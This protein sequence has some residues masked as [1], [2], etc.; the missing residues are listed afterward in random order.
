MSWIRQS[1]AALVRLL[2]RFDYPTKFGVVAIV[3]GFAVSL[4]LQ[5]VFDDHGLTVGAVKQEVAALE[6]VDD[7]LALVVDAQLHR[8]LTYAALQ[9]DGGGFKAM[10][11][12]RAAAV[13]ARMSELDAALAAAPAL[14]V[15][16]PRWDRIRQDLEE[17]LRAADG[18]ATGEHVFERY[19]IAIRG[20]LEWMSDVG[21]ASGLGGDGDPALLHL[22]AA[23]LRSL[24]L[25]VE[26]I[27]NLRG[28][29]TGTLVAKRM[30][31]RT[32]LRLAARLEAVEIAESALH[33]R[34]GAIRADVLDMQAPLIRELHEAVRYI[35]NTAR[36][37]IHSGADSIDPIDFFA[38]ASLAIQH[39]LE[40][41][42]QHLSRG[43]RELLEQR[44]QAAAQD[45]WTSVAGSAAVCAL[46]ALLFA[47]MYASIRRAVAELERGSER[48]AAGALETRVDI[49]SRDELRTVGEHF[50]AM[51][52][53]I[54]GL[55][56]AQREQGRRLE[57]AASVFANAREGIIITDRGGNIVD[58]NGAFTTITGWARD[59]VM[60]KNPRLLKSGRQGAD[61][62]RAMWAVLAEKGYWEGEV[63]NCDKQGKAF[64]EA[65]AISAVRDGDGEVSHYVALISDITRQKE[66]EQRLRRLAHF[67]V[68]TGLPN[69]SLLA[70]RLEQALG[71]ARRSGKPVAVALIDLDGFKAINDG[72]GHEAGDALLVTVARRMKACLRTQD[73]I[74][75]MGG[76][77][78]I[79]VIGELDSHDEV[80][81]PMTRLLAALAAPVELEQGTVR[82][83]GS[84]G[85]TFYPQGG[86]IESEQ[87]IRQADQA[88]YAVK[89]AGKN[90]YRIFTDTTPQPL[91]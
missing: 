57:L 25:F 33:E 54:T 80:R 10:L 73:T 84:I 5:Q 45:L 90:G 74:A 87:L 16:R 37:T 7:A 27:A 12:V 55:I 49:V 15:V 56:E 11:P 47:A 44:R 60:G 61:F 30:D 1:F 68:L 79:A 35:R 4:Y 63:W 66:H 8:G 23:Q 65:L 42:R 40:V 64:A 89:Q 2:D 28:L 17:A 53:K 77:E 58:V 13:R 31:E 38:I 75:R 48:F 39:A 3:F 76:D 91:S 52:D 9:P 29:A 72:Y 36:Q 24:P 83:A 59:E 6:V 78:F 46:V 85:V 50:N 69:R 26:S 82:V 14:E 62:Y 20:V 22:A 18:R 34:I 86:P 21:D 32:R 19:T 88:M 41:H 67:D 70:D 51:A 81:R 43:A 71:R